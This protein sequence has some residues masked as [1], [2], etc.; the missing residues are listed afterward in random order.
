MYQ[1]VL[2]ILKISTQAM[3]ISNFEK[4]KIKLW[5]NEQHKSFENVNICYICKENVKDKYA[6]D[7]KRRKVRNHCHYT[8]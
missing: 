1:K 4:E 2:Q 8:G 3:K 6:K 5:T 7:K